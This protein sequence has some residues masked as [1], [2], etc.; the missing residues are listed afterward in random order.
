MDTYNNF[1]GKKELENAVYYSLRMLEHGL[2]IQQQF[3]SLLSSGNS[4]LLLP[5]LNRLIL[6]INPVTSKPDHLLNVAKLVTFKLENFLIILLLYILKLLYI[7]IKPFAV[8]LNKKVLNS[9][10][11][12]QICYL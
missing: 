7:I 4:S 5:G 12:F 9:I 10:N 3:L 1:A 11:Y 8:S 6:G 2:A